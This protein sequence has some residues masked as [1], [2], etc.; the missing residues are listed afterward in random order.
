MAN[1]AAQM[2]RITDM[3][4]AVPITST[5]YILDMSGDYI[6]DVM[7]LTQTMWIVELL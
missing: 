7:G 5:M 3:T 2:A 4:G 1:L 6:E